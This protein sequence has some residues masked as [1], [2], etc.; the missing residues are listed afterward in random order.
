[1]DRTEME[2]IFGLLFAMGLVHKPTLKDYWST[3]FVVRSSLHRE[4]M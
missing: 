4:I 1:M 2:K 3:D